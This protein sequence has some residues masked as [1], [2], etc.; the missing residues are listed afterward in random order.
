MTERIPKVSIGMPAYN[1]EQWI[2]MAIDSILE[3]DFRDFELIISDNASTDGTE[4]ICREYA[5][6]DSRIR[7]YR[8]PINVG[9][10]DN[11][12]AVFLAARGEYF[13]WASSN[14]FCRLNF[15]SSCVGI[16]DNNPD[17]VL[18][19]PKTRLFS[20]SLDNAEDYEDNLNLTDESACKRMVTLIQNLKLNNIMNGL[21]RSS[22]LR[23]TSLIKPYYA[24]DVVLMAEV[25]IH[26]KFME[27]PEFLF[28][29]RMDPQTATKLKD[30]AE[31]VKHY[32]PTRTKKMIF[33]TWKMHQGY[34]L[35]AVRAPSQLRERIC[36]FKYILRL[37]IWDRHKLTNDV[38]YAFKRKP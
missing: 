26:G 33:Q 20:D 31:V 30:E 1:S 27:F 37:I 4:E 15:I 35:T 11:Y 10:S 29:R 17:V 23:Q 5:A 25:A 9:A 22:I 16:L 18:C 38:I 28:Y 14:D 2:S 8:K 12:N 13:K 7:Y 19:C 32:Y 21:I 24:S 3:Q 6:R 34:F 36:I